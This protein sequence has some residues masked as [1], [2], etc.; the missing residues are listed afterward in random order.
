MIKH[1]IYTKNIFIRNLNEQL[2]L[3]LRSEIRDCWE[4]IKF[5]IIEFQQQQKQQQQQQQQIFVETL[6][7]KNRIS[8]FKGKKKSNKEDCVKILR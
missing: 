7:F 4:I 2:Q 3:K 8:G 6:N 5:I 1:V